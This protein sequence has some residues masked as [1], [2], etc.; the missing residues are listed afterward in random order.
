MVDRYRVWLGAGVL[1]GGFSAAML[2]GA[3]VASAD[4]GSS[5][6]SGS[7][8]K[9]ASTSSDDG[10]G[11]DTTTSPAKDADGDT[12][13][14][15]DDDAGTPTTTPTTIP[16]TIRG[17]PEDDL[18]NGGDEDVRAPEGDE[19]ADDPE[20]ADDVADDE[21]GGDADYGWPGSAAVPAPTPGRHA[22][23]EPEESLP[24]PDPDPI[25]EPSEPT[26]PAEAEA[27]AEP[28][29]PSPLVDSIETDLSARDGAA[30]IQLAAASSPWAGASAFNL[31]DV[32]ED[33]S[34][35]FYNWYTGTMQFL[36]G[37]ARAPFGSRVRVERSSLDLGNGVVVSADWYFPPGKTAPKGL[38]YL[39]HGMLASAS[40]YTATA[41]YLAEKTH[42]IVVAPTL[43]WNVFD[44]DNF[45]L[46][47]PATHRA[48]ADLFSGD[49]EALTASARQAGWRNA[50]PTRVVLVG[51]SAGGGLAAGT[52]RYMVERGLAGDLAG[53]VMLDGAGQYGVLRADL[54]KIPRS[55]PVYNL[56]ATPGA[57]NN[58]GHASQRLNQVRPGMFTGVLVRGGHHSDSM[59]STSGLVQFIAYLATGFSSPWNVEANEILSAGWINDMLDGTYTDRLYR[60]AVSPVGL[61]TGLWLD[62]PSTVDAPGLT[63]YATA[64]DV[65]PVT[66]TVAVC[67]DPLPGRGGGRSPGSTAV[68]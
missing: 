3:G 31:F 44:T 32:V 17:R 23:P 19:G 43:T 28:E 14:D 27:E 33:I 59:Q 34:T 16:G 57:W 15:A 68:A 1:A 55:I 35:M 45:P 37:P 18:D 64:R 42:S 67:T 51:H 38:I 29:P 39:Q 25:I 49:R 50:L 7:A 62:P 56:A 61:V 13:R 26:G 10:G 6:G 9:P 52:A 54:A 65:C 5:T 36:A 11:A 53:V 48:I 22:L 2:G 21:L 63:A 41:A 60:P 8:D 66:P 47:L 12:D 20:E 40:F 58:R 30:V 4:D 46:T 24:T